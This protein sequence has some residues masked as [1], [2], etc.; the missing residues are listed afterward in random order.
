MTGEPRH[1]PGMVGV[2]W[3]EFREPRTAPAER[4]GLGHAR[5]CKVL[6]R[7]VKWS[8]SQFKKAKY[9]EEAPCLLPAPLQKAKRGHGV[10]DRLK[11]ERN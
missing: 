4:R 1:L 8:W 9:P 3:L 2:V 11:R 7:G 10:E 6:S 5:H